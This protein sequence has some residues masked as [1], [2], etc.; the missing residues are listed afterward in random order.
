MPRRKREDY[1][2]DIGVDPRFSSPLIQKFINVV[3]WRGKKNAARTI[4]YGAIDEMTK[5]VKGDERKALEMFNKAFDAVVPIVE[6]RSRRVG[7]SV[8]QIPVE[9]PQKRAQSLAM[10]W[11]LEGAAKRPDKTMADRLAHELMDAYEGRG[12]AMKKKLDVQKMAEAN[13]AFSHYA[14]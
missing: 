3:M 7:G 2:R 10:R 14:W 11:L 6:V 5:R 12:A 13:R 1:T 9:V 4:V 8:Y